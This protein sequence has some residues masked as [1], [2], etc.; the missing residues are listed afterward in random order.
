[1]FNIFY[2]ER[3]GVS[4]ENLL[5]FA[6]FGRDF[7]KVPQRSRVVYGGFGFCANGNL[8]IPYVP[9]E[10][11]IILF[12]DQ[13]IPQKFNC[14]QLSAFLDKYKIKT[15]IFDFERPKNDSLCLLINSVHNANVVIPA[16]Y[17][18]VCRAMILAPAYLPKEPFANYLHR[19]RNR[20]GAGMLDLCPIHC[21]VCDGVWQQTDPL[22]FKNGRYSNSNCCM[23]ITRQGNAG[24]EIHFFDSQKSLLARASA[25][26]LPCLLPLS[27]FE[28]LT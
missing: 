14:E 21:S 19:V 17:A 28:K 7:G 23:Y 16:T 15:I 5:Y 8:R 13:I 24:T 22:H 10:R 27:E 2:H 6:V 20:Y 25:S 18:A 4:M 9:P 3:H 12:D 26:A 11:S 1:M